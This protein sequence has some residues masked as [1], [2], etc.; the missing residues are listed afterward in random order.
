MSSIL[1]ILLAGVFHAA[2]LF[3]VTA[4][5]QLIFGVQRILN[6]ACGSIY[7]LG[8]YVG[9][10]LTT[11]ALANGLPP[12]LFPLVLLVAGLVSGLI[13]IPLER[14]IR[15]VYRR[16]EAFQLLLTFSLILIFQDVIWFFWGAEPQQLSNLTM[17]YGT[18]SVMGVTMPTYNIMLIAVAVL[19]AIGLNYYL[20]AT[21][22]GKI[23]R[24]TAENHET[25]AAMA[26]DVK[27]VYVWVFTLGTTL[28]TLGGA[29][30]IPTT[31]ATLQ[32]GVELV[33]E[34]FAV[35]VLG[36]LGSMKGAIVGALIVGVIRAI[37]LFVYPEVEVLA[38]YAI[39]LAVLIWKPSGLYGKVEA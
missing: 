25:G 22:S 3:L 18:I 35:I 1:N 7:A 28:G 9:I 36:G 8:A 4:G 32:M 24:A 39:V 17:T 21:R 26:I 38:I 12:Y 34:A 29:L 6:L 5:L 19:F 2:T 27:R 16:P 37:A 30:V 33:V 20:N 14:L 31:A 13:G 11:W 10:T 15:S 23:L